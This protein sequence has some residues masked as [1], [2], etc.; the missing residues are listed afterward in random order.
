MTACSPTATPTPFIAPHSPKITPTE[1]AAIFIE[2]A[3]PEPILTE[4]PT[5]TTSP[6]PQ[7]SL[8]PLPDTPIAVTDTPGLT[9]IST[10]SPTPPTCTDSLKYQ[11]DINFPDGS[12]V[13]PGQAVQKQ[14]HVLNDGTCDWDNR[15]HLK[16]VEGYPAMG[17]AAEMALFPARAKAKGIISINFIAPLQSGTYRTVWQASNP[18][19]VAFGEQ[20]YMEIIVRP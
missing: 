15:Y 8:T 6:A 13:L 10:P 5:A 20:I 14:W 1:S 17:A 11:A 4:V 3:T 7:I 9:P 19:G 12:V 16:L 18:E 2:S